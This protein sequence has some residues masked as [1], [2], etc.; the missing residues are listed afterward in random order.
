MATLG[1]SPYLCRRHLHGKDFQGHRV[2]REPV[3]RHPERLDRTALRRRTT[4]IHREKVAPDPH[5]LGG[6]GVHA[7]RPEETKSP[8]PPRSRSRDNRTG[9]TAC[10][11]TRYRRRA[12]RG[13]R[14]AYV[15][16]ARAWSAINS[17][18]PK[19]RRGAS[20]WPR[21]GREGTA[22]PGLA[23][24]GFGAAVRMAPARD[25][26][27]SGAFREPKAPEQGRSQADQAQQY[28]DAWWR[29]RST[30]GSERNG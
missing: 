13:A 24:S 30:R 16:P 25:E 14:A 6:P 23:A 22:T 18:T 20:T 7:R 4:V 10:A 26:L 19:A 3:R 29:T 1:R 21:T 17:P 9:N 28:L 5:T 12:A 11:P 15:V 2:S 8:S 27:R